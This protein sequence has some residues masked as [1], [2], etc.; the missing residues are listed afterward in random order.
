[1]GNSGKYATAKYD[2]G[3]LFGSSVTNG[4]STKY[5]PTEQIK[6][7]GNTSWQGLN[8]TL[9]SLAS[10]DYSNDAN[11]QVYANNLQRQM[12]NNY[13]NSVLG[14]LSKRGLMRSSGLQSATDNFNNTLANQ[15]ASLYDNYSNRLSNNLAN[16]QNVLSNLY[17]MI[18]GVNS[19]SQ[20]LANSVS[21]YNLAQAQT[22]NALYGSL[23]NTAGSLGGAALLASDRRVKKDIKKLCKM[24][25]YNWYEF[26]YKDGYGLPKGKHYGVIAQEVEKIK[27]DAVKIINGIKHV[28]Y[29][30]IGLDK[31]VA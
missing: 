30:K 3:G 9:N 13:N 19:G 28:D 11:Y 5:K 12:T 24:N 22:N 20:N 6:Q 29:S 25:G 26:R 23:A 10:G 31:E 4:Q 15:T 2:T 17:N 18:T 21:S 7:A 14:N 1:M 8:N 27:P 16:Y